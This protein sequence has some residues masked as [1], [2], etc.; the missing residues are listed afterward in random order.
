MQKCENEEE[1]NQMLDDWEAMNSTLIDMFKVML[2]SLNISQE[3][4]ERILKA[5]QHLGITDF[6]QYMEHSQ[7][8]SD[9]LRKLVTDQIKNQI[10]DLEDNIETIKNN[11]EVDI[12]N[13]KASISVLEKFLES[14]S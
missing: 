9:M 8:Y 7:K 2:M 11:S 10:S 5:L 13:N 3:Q 12:N 14:R 1:R 6:D 4:M